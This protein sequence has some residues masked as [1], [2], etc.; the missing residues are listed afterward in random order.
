M[1]LRIN[2]VQV[3][4]KKVIAI[5]GCE[6]KFSDEDV[7]NWMARINRHVNDLNLNGHVTKTDCKDG[8][9]DDCDGYHRK[10]WDVKVETIDENGIAFSGRDALEWV[11]RHYIKR[12]YSEVYNQ[13]Y[14]PIGTEMDLDVNGV[15]EVA[16]VF[17]GAWSG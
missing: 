11:G 16:R 2:G 12:M 8:C 5:S 10:S 15:C 14:E 6:R 1:L 7:E 17:Y 3:Q 13:W 4:P 9:K